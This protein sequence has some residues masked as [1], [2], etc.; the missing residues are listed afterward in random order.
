MIIL[1][2]KYLEYIQRFYD[3]NLIKVLTGIRRAG[4]S[5]LLKQ[6]QQELLTKYNISK[7]HIIAINFEETKYANL[8]SFIEVEDYI[9]SFI[10]DDNKYYIFL[11]EIQH[12]DEFERM[13]ASLKASKNV[14]IF[15]TG[16]NSKLLSGSL[17]TL[18]V[19]R[20]KEFKIMPFSYL[21][22]I[23][24]YKENNLEMPIEP[25][26]NYIKYG[27]MPQRIDYVIEEDIK[28]YLL[29][30]YEGIIEKDICNQK[31]NIDK[32]LFNTISRY[33][34]TNATKEFSA[35][36]IVKYYNKN[37]SDK[38]YEK[39]IYR[40][41]EKMEEACLISRVRRYDIA[42]KRT[43]QKIEKHYLIDNGFLFACSDT[44]QI[45]LAHGLENIIY[46]ELILRGYD[47]RIGKTYKGEIDFV[48]MKFGKK[49][50]I[51]VCYSLADENVVKREFS[52]YDSVRDNS[53]KFVMSMDRLD[54]SHN[55]I[56]HINIEEWLLNKVDIFLI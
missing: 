12:I 18:L 42:T 50:F 49:C 41:L 53:P 51:Q 45:F 13:L 29:S 48:A 14:S 52:A 5:I 47:V 7:D 35:S 23:Q 15:I 24:Y 56:T 36:S 26:T 4:K 8:K 25:L 9:L 27:G 22:F 6:I 17:A 11:D 31:N 16:S 46:N 10:K 34:I 44:N 3:S 19:G 20:C 2:K 33:I 21:E 54:F 55:Q 43:L 39:Q 28:N 1:R 40:Y 32:E 30:I 37:N 38:I